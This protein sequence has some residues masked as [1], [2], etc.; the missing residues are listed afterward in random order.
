M[1]PLTV[2]IVAAVAIVAIRA[3][4]T[5]QAADR[6]NYQ[7]DRIVFKNVGALSVNLVLRVIVNNPSYS[8]IVIDYFRFEL[9]DDAGTVFATIYSSPNQLIPIAAR[10]SVTVDIPFALSNVGVIKIIYQAIQGGAPRSVR[11]RGE[12][13]ANGFAAPVDQTIPLTL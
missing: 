5:A 1:N 13:H 10:S 11:I 2:I 9:L 12:V 4:S 8:K 6:L 3:I 7:F